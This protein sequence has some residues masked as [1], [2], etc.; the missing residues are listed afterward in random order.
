MVFFGKADFEEFCLGKREEDV[1]RH[2]EP[3]RCA[4]SD[5]IAASGEGTDELEFATVGFHLGFELGESRFDARSR[6]DQVGVGA[7][8]TVS[9]TVT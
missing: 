6:S 4:A 3:K 2:A 5:D 8:G 9:G 1:K 7:P